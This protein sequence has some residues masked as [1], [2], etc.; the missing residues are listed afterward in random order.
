[1]SDKELWNKLRI[2][3]HE[4]FA[5]IYDSH[6]EALFQYG[7]RFSYRKQTI[8]DAVHDLFVYIWNNRNSLGKTDSIS[9]YLMVALR[10]RIFKETKRSQ[11]VSD[12]KDAETYDFLAESSI[13]ENIMLGEIKLE[14]DRSLKVAIERLSTRQKEVIYLKYFQDF[15]YEDICE[16][17]DISYQSVRNLTFQ[18]LKALR[19]LITLMLIYFPFAI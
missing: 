19:K 16:I 6:A 4:A 7:L 11:K 9:R 5:T 8:E 15:S 18:S 12:L 13:A 2:G 3:D 1:M 14:N 10:R 17:M